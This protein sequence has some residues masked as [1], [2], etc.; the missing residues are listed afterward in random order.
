M[1]SVEKTICEILL[2]FIKRPQFSLRIKD[3][4]GRAE[5]L[6]L[7][8]I[9]GRK[10]GWLQSRPAIRP[11]CPKGPVFSSFCSE[12]TPG[13]GRLYPP[14]EEVATTKVTRPSWSGMPKV[15][16]NFPTRRTRPGW[17]GYHRHAFS[18]KSAIN[19]FFAPV[20]PCPVIP[21]GACFRPG[22]QT[23]IETVV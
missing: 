16:R 17:S 2:Q 9:P 19:R 13:F 22:T 1:L 6:I 5:I 11:I 4:F 14:P 12:N 8:E 21:D 3:N 7:T 18:R 15:K 10:G 23:M 20:F